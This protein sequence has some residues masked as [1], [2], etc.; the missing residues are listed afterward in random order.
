MATLP[1]SAQWAIAWIL[2]GRQRND[3]AL[4]RVGF[5]LA[6]ALDP[7]DYHRFTKALFY[8]GTAA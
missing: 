7:D 8:Y 2:T 3:N 1:V 4:I 6:E 5:D